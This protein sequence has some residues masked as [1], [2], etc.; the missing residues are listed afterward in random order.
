MNRSI[1][2]NE[3]TGAHEMVF[4]MQSV[5]ERDGDWLKVY[6]WPIPAG[7]SGTYYWESDMRLVV[8]GATPRP[9]AASKKA[10]AETV[11]LHKLS[12]PELQEQAAKAGI[13]PKG[14]KK[15]QLVGALLEKHTP[16]RLLAPPGE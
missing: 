3:T 2:F 15:G 10:V 1:R 7:M 4:D 16:R 5:S 9:D 6:P 8:P 13:D 11:N 14:K 12:E